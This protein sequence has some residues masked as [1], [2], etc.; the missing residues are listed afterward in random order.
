MAV[1]QM[2][3]AV[4]SLGVPVDQP[5]LIEEI[6]LACR[7]HALLRGLLEEALPSL[8]GDLRQRVEDALRETPATTKRRAT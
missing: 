3:P 7:Q 5:E 1:L 2:R 6:V 8:S 4:V